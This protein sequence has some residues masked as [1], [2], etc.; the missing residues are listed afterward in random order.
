MSHEPT[1]SDP[2]RA[3][4]PPD[5]LTLEEAGK[6]LKVSARTVRREIADGRIAAVAVRSSLRITAAEL[7]RYI[8]SRESRCQSENTVN[9]GKFESLS[10]VAGALSKHFRAEQPGPTRSRSKLRSG[11]RRSTL[12]LVETSDTP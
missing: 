3:F 10:A 4:P 9:A 7:A 11:A 8:A 5:L 6:R 1:T 2:L 12:R